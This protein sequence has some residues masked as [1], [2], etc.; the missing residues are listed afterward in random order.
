[1]RDGVSFHGVW[2]LFDTDGQPKDAAGSR[3][4]ATAMLDQLTWWGHALR[5]ARERRPY[6]A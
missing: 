5:D 4:V 1:M 2:G 3:K 6:A